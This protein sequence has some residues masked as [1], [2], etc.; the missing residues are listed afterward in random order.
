[1]RAKL[2][3]AGGGVG[4]RWVGPRARGGGGGGRRTPPTLAF[5]AWASAVTYLPTSN[6]LF[7]SGIVLAERT[8]YL[9]VLLVAAL[10]GW[11]VQWALTRW[12]PRRV[13]IAA[14]ALLLGL[15]GRTVT[16]LPVW[17][18]NRTFLL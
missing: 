16:R 8:L 9:P 12:P 3:I 2:G 15:L 18:D 11:V 6:L 10:A 4:G 14:A 17:R 5:A 7:P 13:G 1:M